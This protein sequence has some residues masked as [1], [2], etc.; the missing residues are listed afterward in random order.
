MAPMS[1]AEPLHNALEAHVHALYSQCIEAVLANEYAES[2]VL[3]A[4]AAAMRVATL[5]PH[6]NK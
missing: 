4:D 5:N 6:A 1:V 3:A 2:L